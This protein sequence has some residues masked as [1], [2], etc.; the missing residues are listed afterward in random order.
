[1]KLSDELM[2]R[3]IAL[4]AAA[5]SALTALV[6]LGADRVGPVAHPLEVHLSLPALPSLVADKK[7]TVDLCDCD[8][9][10]GTYTPIP[11]TGNMIVTGGVGNGAAA[12]SWRLYLPPD[13]RRYVKAQVAVETGGGSNIA[14]SLTLEFRV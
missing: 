14:Q 6:D 9:S 11:T 4:P 7:V 2:K 1:M 8:T 13:T 5:A 10:G 3:I 12:K